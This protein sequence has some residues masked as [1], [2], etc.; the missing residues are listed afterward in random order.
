MTAR[1]KILVLAS[2]YPR[3]KNDRE[4]GFVH[5]LSRRLFDT[6]DVLVVTPH[7]AGALLQE[8]LDGV[9]V[10]RFRYAP[11]KLQT[12]VH[13]GGMIHNLR[14]SPWK[15]LLVPA[16]FI[17]NILA[18]A[19]QLRRENISVI[20]A[21]W[22]FPQGMV[23]VI[24]R[25]FSGKH[26]PILVTSHG[27][28]LYALKGGLFRSLKKGVLRKSSFVTV[29]SRA[30]SP[31]IE[32]LGVAPE[33]IAVAPMGVD[34]Q[35]LFT[36]D[37]NI[38]R[39]KN[40]LLF[41][42]RLVEKKGLHVLIEA[43]PAIL[44]QIPGVELDVVGFGPEESALRSRVAILG[45]ENVVS[46]LGGMPQS[47]LPGKYRQAA[48]FVAPFVISKSGDQEG[49][50]LVVVEAIACGCPAIV[51]D[52]PATADII[53]DNAF[54][55]PSNNSEKLAEAIYGVLSMDSGAR[56]A[57]ASTQKGAVVE[58]LGWQQ[59]TKVYERILVKIDDSHYS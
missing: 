23:A 36:D 8:N 6:F 30:M 56:R 29:V 54:R 16:F 37:P 44:K 52:I 38:E 31:I 41:V 45:L 18:T 53:T 57:L 39:S 11:K 9:E 4:P 42:G 35:T 17:G 22:I 10:L 40:R 3:W 55:V 13:D 1:K 26:V 12:L 46:F 24:A 50:G 7:A 27:A 14:A 19:K 59:V 32:Q 48:L 47:E 58:R 49:L 43:L 28:D 51:T 20:H 25:M 2:T 15:W 21:H 34:M 33:K 5:E